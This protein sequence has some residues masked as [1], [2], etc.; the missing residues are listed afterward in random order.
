MQT[1]NNII[2]ILIPAVGGQGG[3]V[4]TE[5]LVTAFIN[6]GYEVQ[7]I[8]LPGLSQRAGSTV[9]Y[10]E[11]YKSDNSDNIIFSQYPIPGD[12]DIIIC[13][14]FLELGRVLQEGYGSDKTTIVSSTHRIYSTPEKL[15]VSSGVFSNEKIQNLAEE[16]SSIFIGIDALQIA[17]DNDMEYLAINA[18]IFGAMCASGSLPLSTDTL[19]K[20]IEQVGIAVGNNLK[21]F[22][23]GIDQIRD[24]L[25]S[26]P[27]RRLDLDKFIDDKTQAIRDEYK[28]DFMILTEYI[29]KNYSD[30]LQL[31]L[32][33]AV[34]RLIDYQNPDYA[35]KY[36]DIVSKILKTDHTEDSQLTVNFAK[37]LALLM[38]FEDGIR[39]AE[40]K[41][42]SVR[43]ENIKKEMQI[44]SNQIISI[45]DYLKPDSYEIYGLLPNFIINPIK[46]L[47]DNTPLIMLKRINK[48]V[49][50]AQK[51]RTS[52]IFGFLRLYMLSKLKFMRPFSHRYHNEYKNIN[53]YVERTIRYTGQN[54][55]LGLL[56]SRSGSLIKGYGDVRRKTTDIFNRFL[57]NIIW[58]VSMNLNGNS[59]H[60]DT[61]IEFSE[62]CLD[63]ISSE[64][65]Q[66]TKFEDELKKTSLFKGADNG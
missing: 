24:N 2:K 63:A 9:N 60:D 20:A 22:N 4:M 43:F 44:N 42:K 19:K 64:S 27:K 59:E 26:A 7:S 57:D 1:D 55:Q 36:L 31:Y 66:I 13:Q 53:K 37:N 56:V 11:A 35:R 50:F 45:T 6:D 21:A 12:V 15:P 61:L 28:A 18:I 51:P 16:F 46:I 29:G 30:N 3:G 8:S 5:W 49:T 34:H 23:V 52:S 25:I 65:E 58:P 10:I 33:E 40:L 41:V 62:K 38:S 54:K 17:K 47:I 48:S 39:V 14:E 32:I